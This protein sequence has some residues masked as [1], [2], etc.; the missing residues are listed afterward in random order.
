MNTLTSTD[1]AAEYK[2]LDMDVLKRINKW[3]TVAIPVVGALP[4]AAAFLVFRHQPGVGLILM[5]TVLVFTLRQARKV[6]LLNRKPVVYSGIITDK[7]SSSHTN[8]STKTSYETFYIRILAQEAFEIDWRGKA[9][10]LDKA[11]KPVKLGCSSSLYKILNQGQSITV[12]VLPHEKEI[13]KLF[14]SN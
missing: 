2:S 9:D 4:V 5:I 11:N 10:P 13:L 1:W 7:N 12:M 6:Y 3:M 14:P 8:E